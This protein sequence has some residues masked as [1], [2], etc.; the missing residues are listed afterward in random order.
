MSDDNVRVTDAGGDQDHRQDIH[1]RIVA[2]MVA[3]LIG[4]GKGRS[5]EHEM[6]QDFHAPFR[7]H[8]IR[9]YDADKA[10]HGYKVIDSKH[11]AGPRP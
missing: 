6:R 1:K 5:R 9:Q 8:E 7:E 10:R 3:D 11:F 2:G 4:D